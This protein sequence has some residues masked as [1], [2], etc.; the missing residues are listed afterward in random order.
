MADKEDREPSLHDFL[1]LG[2]LEKA[3]DTEKRQGKDSHHRKEEIR[4]LP[5]LLRMLSA[6]QPL[7]SIPSITQESAP[8]EEKTTDPLVEQVVS[9]LEDVAATYSAAEGVDVL[10]LHHAP[11]TCRKISRLPP[12][13]RDKRKLE[14]NTKD[15]AA[16]AASP[17]G[18]AR[19]KRRQNENASSGPYQ[20]KVRAND[21][22]SDDDDMSVEESTDFAA[23]LEGTLPKTSDA[24]ADA[25][26]ASSDSQEAMT[27]KS[28]IEIAKLVVASLE[29]IAEI[30]DEDEGHA[31]QLLSVMTDA[32]LSEPVSALDTTGS[33]GAVGGC[34]LGATVAALMHHAPVLR[35]R[36]LAVSEALAH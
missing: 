18:P 4:R 23:P 8:I 5:L 28:L 16:V 12:L 14:W 3:L 19:K 34:D 6:S 25:Q 31:S 11:T 2:E 17:L 7:S 15:L 24:G 22:I 33:G 20:D 36:H 32:L 21:V 9:R 26:M 35:H 29:P 10:T 30:K 27:T 13:K 1:A